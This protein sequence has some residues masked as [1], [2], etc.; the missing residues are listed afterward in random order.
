MRKRLQFRAHKDSS[1]YDYG[2][3]P[4]EMN[5]DVNAGHTVVR[6]LQAVARHDR[7]LDWLG[8]ALVSLLLVFPFVVQYLPLGVREYLAVTVR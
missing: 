1:A 7:S 3:A 5:A 8:V 6:T 4:E 2:A